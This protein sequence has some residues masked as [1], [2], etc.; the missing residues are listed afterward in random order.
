[1]SAHSTIAAALCLLLGA[2]GV[3]RAEPDPAVQRGEYL[4]RVGGCI[5]CHSREDGAPATG[6]EAI[7]TPF[8]SF[9]PPNL[10]PDPATG[11]GAWGWGD[12]ERA[13]REGLRPDGSP[14][15]PAFPYPAF[16][17]IRDA[18]LR[19]L[20]AYLRS[21]PATSAPSP[22][23]ELPWYLARPL[24]RVW[25]WLFFDPGEY[26]PDPARDDAWNNG[27]Y[28]AEALAHCSE[29]HTPRNFLG[30]LDEE[31]LYAGTREGPGGE[32]VPNITPDRDT[33]IGRWSRDDLAY[34][35]ET[36]A[37]PDGDYAGGLMAEAIDEGLAYLTE[38]DRN[39]L[40]EYIL[41]LPPKLHRVKEAKQRSKRRQEF[42]Y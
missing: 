40:V 37:D 14:Y 39:D 15:Y 17:R 24:V 3:G 32:T 35:L 16:T 25:R 41:S 29:C 27:A 34:Y 31:W 21:L 23:H 1:V 18:D 7:K 11:L 13:M 4:A 36:G 22:E 6:G 38:S 5:A 28:I 12:F 42:D 30:G 8:G 33:G 2:A 19:A 9:Y 26:R 20:W 10:T